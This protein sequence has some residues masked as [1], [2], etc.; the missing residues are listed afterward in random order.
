M[1]LQEWVAQGNPM[2]SGHTATWY[3][4]MAKIRDKDLRQI[5]LED[6]FLIPR[7]GEVARREI[8]RWKQMM[9]IKKS[10]ETG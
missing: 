7:S 1:T 10:M 2:L 5:V 4:Q 9:V 6:I 8:L 3:C